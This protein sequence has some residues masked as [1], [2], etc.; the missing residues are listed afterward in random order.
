MS[1]FRNAAAGGTAGQAQQARLSRGEQGRSRGSGQPSCW[2]DSIALWASPIKF[3]L[4]IGPQEAAV[5]F[6]FPT[7]PACP[8]AQATPPHLA[9][10]TPTHLHLS[11]LGNAGKQLYQPLTG[12]SYTIRLCAEVRGSV[13][14][15]GAQVLWNEQRGQQLKASSSSTLV[16]MQPA[17]QAA[18]ASTSHSAVETAS[19]AAHPPWHS[20]TT[21]CLALSVAW[22]AVRQAGGCMH[23]P[24]WPRQW[25]VSPRVVHAGTTHSSR[26]LQQPAPSPH[27]YS[28]VRGWERCT[29]ELAQ[30]RA[31]QVPQGRTGDLALTR[32]R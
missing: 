2:P 29:S 21:L 28:P 20:H 16:R 17:Q 27:C 14:L 30:G 4:R 6:P 7:P 8:L 10:L 15:Q 5:P 32:G 9:A 13:R 18:T 12:G 24:P 23:L 25:P 3:G 26:R 11:R 22:P 19:R 1:T 31:M